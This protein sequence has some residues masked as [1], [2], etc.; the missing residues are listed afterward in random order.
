METELIAVG[1]NQGVEN[2]V[3]Y[4]NI[5]IVVLMV[6]V[7]FE[8]G[9]IVALLRGLLKTKDVLANLATAITILNERLGHHNDSD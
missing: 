4:D 5:A 6:M 2:I 1:L 8:G 3:N 7:L 9:L